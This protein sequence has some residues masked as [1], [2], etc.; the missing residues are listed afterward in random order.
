MKEMGGDT[1][2]RQGGGVG[3]S[4]VWAQKLSLLLLLWVLGNPLVL[5]WLPEGAR[6]TSW[7]RVSWLR[8]LAA[9]L[10]A[11]T[12]PRAQALPLLST[13]GQHHPSI[14]PFSPQPS[15]ESWPRVL[16]SPQQEGLLSK[17]HLVCSCGVD[18]CP[19]PSLWRLGSRAG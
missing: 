10:L 15:R 9:Q 6:G 16:V 14:P 18:T 13:K 12:F 2:K 17:T 8:L 5:V 19:A 3:K 7:T 11:F 1:R 4:R